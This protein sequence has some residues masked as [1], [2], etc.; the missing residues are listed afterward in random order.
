MTRLST[1]ADRSRTL[2]DRA[3]S[4]GLHP[5]HLRLLLAVSKGHTTRAAL[6]KATGRHPSNVTRG[7]R[8]L[9]KRDLVT[10][11]KRLTPWTGPLPPGASKKPKGRSALDVQLT[12]AG[13]EVLREV[14]G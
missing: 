6:A 1:L 12:D 2:E 8:G 14:S 7:V 11:A 10:S 13:R 5:S 3:R 4:V 9:V